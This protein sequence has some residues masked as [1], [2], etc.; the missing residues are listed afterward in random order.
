MHKD[1]FFYYNQIISVVKSVIFRRIDFVFFY[2]VLNR[3]H[4]KFFL[5]E[6]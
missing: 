2:C 5:F 6:I 4:F 1:I 3:K